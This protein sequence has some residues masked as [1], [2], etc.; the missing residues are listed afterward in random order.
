[1]LLFCFFNQFRPKNAAN[2]ILFGE[3]SHPGPVMDNFPFPVNGIPS[4][5]F[6]IKQCNDLM[7][8][9]LTEQIRQRQLFIQEYG[10]SALIGLHLWFPEVDLVGTNAPK[11]I[12]RRLA[13]LRDTRYATGTIAKVTNE[14]VTINWDG[15]YNTDLPLKKKNR[16][17]PHFFMF[18][19]RVLMLFLCYIYLMLCPCCLHFPLSSSILLPLQVQYIKMNEKGKSKRSRSFDEKER[20]KKK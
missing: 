3:A 10:L 8:P 18:T 16:Y 17:K 20:G 1:M 4:S 19:I 12:G 11:P 5:D 9:A 13:N 15:S 7:Y 14:F 2:G 6:T